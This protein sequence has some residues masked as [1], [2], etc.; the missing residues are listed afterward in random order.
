MK[1]FLLRLRYFKKVFVC[2]ASKK[3]LSPEVVKSLLERSSLSSLVILVCQLVIERAK[4]LDN[5]TKPLSLR[6]L[7]DNTNSYKL[8]FKI[9][10]LIILANST[11]YNSLEDKFRESKFLFFCSPF[12]TFIRQLFLRE[13]A[14][15]FKNYKVKLC[16][17][18]L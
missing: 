17:N 6:S 8:Q 10:S 14:D 12:I 11:P 7:L 3:T 16:S 1:L 13:V 4:I 18:K 9:V 2:K 15:M 5:I